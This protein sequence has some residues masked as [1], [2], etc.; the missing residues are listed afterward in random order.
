MPARRKR[1]KKSDSKFLR[2]FF[3]VFLPILIVFCAIVFILST[4]Y[5]WDKQDKLAVVVNL[6]SEVE[7][8]VFDP[9]N[10]SIYSVIIPNETQVEV[11]RQLGGWKIGSV[12]E[13]GQ[14]EGVEG[15][16]LAETVSRYFKFPTTVWADRHADDFIKGDYGNLVKAILSSYP[17]NLGFG[18]KLKIALFS[19]GTNNTNKQE[20]HLAHTTYLKEGNL[21][22]GSVGYKLFGKIPEK[23][24]LIFGNSKISEKNYKVSVINRSSSRFIAQD[25]GEVIEVL[26]AK[27]VLVKEEDTKEMDCNVI[28][29]DP[30]FSKTIHNLFGCEEIKSKPEGNIDVEVIV[31]ENFIERY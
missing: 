4:T 24:A 17:T 8:I 25:L 26:G 15:L 6:N 3:R 7:I 11:A 22:D 23:L 18:D 21:K 27:V 9:V 2:V 16:L 31:G 29:M 28:G 13:L 5:H 1:K 14:N 10:E 12:W 19:V 20:I 30:Y